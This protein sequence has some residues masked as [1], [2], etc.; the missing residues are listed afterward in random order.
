MLATIITSLGIIVGA[1]MYAEMPVPASRGWTTV[2]IQDLK[3]RVVDLQLMQNTAR[4]DVFRKEKFDREQEVKKTPGDFQ[5]QQRLE[6]VQDT[7]IEIENERAR[8][9]KERNGQ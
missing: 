8:L 9:L 5:L 6:S 4:R 3:G 1:Y 7:L 2:Q